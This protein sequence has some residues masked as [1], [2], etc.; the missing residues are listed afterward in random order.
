MVGD[1]SLHPCMDYRGLDDII[2]KNQYPLPLVL[3][4]FELLQ[5]VTMLTKLD[6]RNTYHLVCIREGDEWKTAFNTSA[7]NYEYLLMPF[8][9]TNAPAVFQRLVNDVLWD[10]LNCFV[11]VYIDNILIFS[12]SLEEHVQHVRAVLLRCC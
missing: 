5:G 9:L 2:V 6:L 7:G 1:T 4:A 10:M 8:G 12:L 11:F 3:S